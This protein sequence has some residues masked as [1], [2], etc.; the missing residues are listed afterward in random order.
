MPIYEYICGS[1]KHEFEEL[2][3]ASGS[4]RVRCP[5]CESTKTER[6]LSVFAARQGASKPADM[7]SAPGPCSSCC[8]PGGSC[9]YSG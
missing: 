2:T 4:N 5:K 1:C 3:S 7:P 8:D 6:K 9:P